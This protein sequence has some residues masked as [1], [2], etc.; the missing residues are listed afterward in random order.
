METDADFVQSKAVSCKVDRNSETVIIRVFRSTC[1]I[2]ERQEIFSKA[3]F[4][5]KPIQAYLPL[6]MGSWNMQEYWDSDIFWFC[7]SQICRV[8]PPLCVLAPWI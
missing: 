6:F 3:C 4:T 8:F 5:H 1:W 7:D 2:L